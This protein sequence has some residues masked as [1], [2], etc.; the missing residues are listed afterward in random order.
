MKKVN[1]IINIT[2]AILIVLSIGARIYYMDKSATAGEELAQL[3]TEIDVIE[4]ENQIL[5][6]KYY[7]LTSLS[8]ISERAQELG[9]VSAVVDYYTSPS[10][11]SR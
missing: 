7:S 11:A 5:Q 8:S 3:T 6:N 1:K 9:Y 10:L 2:L 4:K